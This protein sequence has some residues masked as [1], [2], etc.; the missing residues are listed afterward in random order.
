MNLYTSQDYFISNYGD[1]VIP[2]ELLERYIKKASRE[3]DL[4]VIHPIVGPLVDGEEEIIE[5]CCCELMVFLYKNRQIEQS[6]M[7]SFSIN[8]VSGEFSDVEYRQ[9]KN[10]ILN[11]LE[12]TRFMDRCFHN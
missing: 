1:K 5:D 2:L 8:G 9:S 4:Y 11:Q 12:L 7:K 6:I 3:I 10:N